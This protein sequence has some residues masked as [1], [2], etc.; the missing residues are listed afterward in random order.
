MSF[1]KKKGGELVCSKTGKNRNSGR[2]YRWLRWVFPIAGL[3]S[4]IW[5]LVRVISK[6]S[7]ATY[8][9][10]RFAFPLASGF[11]AW[12]LGL[13]AWAVAFRKAKVS[14]ARRRYVIGLVCLAVS[15]GALWLAVSIGSDELALAEPH[16]ANESMGAGQGIY[17]GR[18]VWVHDPEATDWEGPGDGHTTGD[19]E[20]GDDGL[21]YVR[22]ERSGTNSGRIYT[23]TYQATDDSGNATV[24]S[25]TVSIPHDF[26]VLARIGER[27][28]SENP[29]GSIPADLNSD[30]IVNL[31]DFAIFAENWIK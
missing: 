23:I 17:P 11:V 26:R 29:A 16:A 19:I 27:W 18:V 15:V 10:Q 6:P 12:L 9:C 25:G 5:F 7:R 20:I 8:P 28:L 4:L 1:S 14:F 21:I 31:T 2:R 13:G 22:S 3:V 24:R 30:G